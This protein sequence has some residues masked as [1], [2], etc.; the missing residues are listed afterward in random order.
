MR[1]YQIYAISV[2]TLIMTTRIAKYGRT[3]KD[4][5]IKNRSNLG[6]ILG[7]HRSLILINKLSKFLVSTNP[8]QQK[9]KPRQRR[10]Q[11]EV[12]PMWN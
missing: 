11:W 6:Q 7:Q 5:L 10:E 9:I 12:K 4:H 8:D 3:V 2:A 1:D